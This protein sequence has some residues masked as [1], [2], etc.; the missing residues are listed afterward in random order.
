MLR[1]LRLSIRQLAR[2]PWFALSADCSHRDPTRGAGR[3]RSRSSARLL[4]PGLVA[5]ILLAA[6]AG[7]LVQAAFVDVDVLSPLL[8]AAV[9]LAEAAIVGLACLWPAFK[10]SRA[11][12]LLAL[13]TE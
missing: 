1:D 2:R 5:G 3:P 6:L 10:A 11:D 4:V 8:Y 13:R 12:P 7:R 9:A